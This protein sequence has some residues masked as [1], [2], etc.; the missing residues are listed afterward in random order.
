MTSYQFQAASLDVTDRDLVIRRQQMSGLAGLP[1]EWTIPLSAVSGVR[2]V[3]PK[4]VKIGYIQIFSYGVDPGPLKALG[5]LNDQNTVTVGKKHVETAAALA[6]WLEALGSH[7]HGSGHSLTWQTESEDRKLSRQEVRHHNLETYG[8]CIAR[9]SIGS[10]VKI[11]DKGYVKIGGLFGTHGRYEELVSIEASADVSK[12]TGVGRAGVG[13][14]TLGL[15]VATTS[16]MRG[17]LYLTITTTTDVYVL[18]QDG[19]SS[20][21]MK[22]LRTLEAAGNSVI[23]RARS[24]EPETV[25]A[26]NPEYGIPAPARNLAAELTA[27]GQLRQQGL[28]SDVEFSNAKHQLL[29]G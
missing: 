4:G 26:M 11:Y 16:N 27:L 14:L 8:E 2:F 12:K 21:S 9:G 29:G 6:N 5:A 7:N 10:S 13:V 22:E 19:A 1:K 3:E 28:L 23:G 15:N 18:H 20:Y 24:Y 25:T 17:D